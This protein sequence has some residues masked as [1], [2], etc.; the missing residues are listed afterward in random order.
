MDRS[1]AYIAMCRPAAELQDLWRCRHGDYYANPAGE[2]A[3]WIADLDGD[4]RVKEGVCIRSR[5]GVI[6]LDR[7]TWLPRLDQLIELAQI[8]GVS[9]DTVTQYFFNWTKRTYRMD[10]E[11]LSGPAELFH[12]LEQLWL[13]FL[14]ARRFGRNWNQREWV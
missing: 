8:P 5:G 1:E 10:Q 14:M 7:F 13:G 12:S 2:I 3:C 9:Y 6:Q 4:A 11:Q